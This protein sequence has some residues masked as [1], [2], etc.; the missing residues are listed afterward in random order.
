MPA[1][2]PSTSFAVLGLLS[3]GDE[4]SGYDLK[5]WADHSLRFFYW[6]PAIAHIYRELKRLEAIGLVESREVALDES[7]HKRLFRIT[8]DGRE[9]L[10][11]WIAD[12]PAEQSIVKDQALLRVWMGHMVEPAQLRRLV[13]EQRVLDEQLLAD[14]RRTIAG[15]SDERFELSILV[16]RFCE[17]LYEGR[18]QALAELEAA[19]DQARISAGRAARNP[20]PRGAK[21][22]K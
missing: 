4:L 14:L 1:G 10:A 17:R 19:L 3:F 18:L 6:S 15:T 12:T 5:K 9:T 13:A 20:G 16:E 7:R 21:P 22:P 11:E 8:D 2:L